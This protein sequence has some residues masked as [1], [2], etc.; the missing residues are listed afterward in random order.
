MSERVISDFEV[1]VR[2]TSAAITGL[3]SID[4]NGEWTSQDI[5][6]QAVDIALES[7]LELKRRKS[8]GKEK[9]FSDGTSGAGLTA[10]MPNRGAAGD[11]R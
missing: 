7:Q 11:H 10:A 9:K 2:F 8:G 5:A 3:I 4:P 1:L 6:R